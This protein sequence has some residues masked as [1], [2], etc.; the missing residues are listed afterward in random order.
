MSSRGG[1][2]PLLELDPRTQWEGENVAEGAEGEQ[3]KS[4]VGGRGRS[5]TSRHVIAEF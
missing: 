3:D 5:C 4:D 2:L 1:L